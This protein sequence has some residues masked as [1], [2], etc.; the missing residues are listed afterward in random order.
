MKRANRVPTE[1][2]AVPSSPSDA[3]H[4]SVAGK[5]KT[6]PRRSILVGGAKFAAFVTPAMTVLLMP[7]KSN[8]CHNPNQ[9]SPS[10]SDPNHC[11]PL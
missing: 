10:P 5:E 7:Q 3:T 2:P 1:N 6:L 11:S 4:S 8:A 9:P